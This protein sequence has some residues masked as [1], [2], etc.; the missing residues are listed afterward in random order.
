MIQN[1]RFISFDCYFFSL[2]VNVQE[3]KKNNIPLEK[4]LD[5]SY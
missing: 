1:E 2:I 5:K 3:L 4:N